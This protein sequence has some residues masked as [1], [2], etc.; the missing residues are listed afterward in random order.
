[1]KTAPMKIPQINAKRQAQAG[2][3]AL[4]M[5]VLAIGGC[6]KEDMADQPRYDP[7]EHSDFF[8]NGQASRP[9][10]EG[11][12]A[13]GHAPVQDQLFAVT[14]INMNTPEATAFPTPLTA[15]DLEV[16]HQKFD[17]F[18]SVCHGRL[19]DANGMVV[20][21]GF[22]KPPSFIVHPGMTQRELT[23]QKA[24]VGHYYNVMTY[25]F[26]AM[27]SYGDRIHPED[28]WKIVAYIKALQLG[29]QGAAGTAAANAAAATG[30]A[31][32]QPVQASA[33]A[34]H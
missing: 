14:S 32:T 18:C 23:L 13:R 28:R 25:G 12:V 15:A 9:L 34:E 7:L 27:Y 10:V 6:R 8:A 30:A 20:Q 21:R 31:T 19:G 33:N 4:V 2:V 22:P 11:T 17:I 24:P 29:T 26:G 1:M 5:M 16:G 3:V